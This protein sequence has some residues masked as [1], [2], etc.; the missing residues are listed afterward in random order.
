MQIKLTQR[1][2]FTLS[3]FIHHAYSGTFFSQSVYHKENSKASIY[4][5]KINLRMR[6]KILSRLMQVYQKFNYFSLYHSNIFPLP[7]C[8]LDGHRGL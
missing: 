4:K 3:N 8:L 2:S 7:F 5:I 1:E 6:Y